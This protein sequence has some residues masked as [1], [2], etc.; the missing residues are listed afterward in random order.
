MLVMLGAVR[1][2]HGCMERREKRSVGTSVRMPCSS[3][4]PGASKPGSI[5]VTTHP[6]WLC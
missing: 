6:C 1:A 3:G 4:C 2:P 5:S